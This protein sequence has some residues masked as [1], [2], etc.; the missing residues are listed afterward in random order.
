MSIADKSSD[1]ADD[2]SRNFEFKQM[3]Q[4]SPGLVKYKVANRNYK[5][6]EESQG[7]S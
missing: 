5:I 3:N 1:K 6:N 7:V 2:N 4:T